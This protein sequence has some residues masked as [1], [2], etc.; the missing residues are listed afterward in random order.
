MRKDLSNI[1]AY[2]VFFLKTKDKIIVWNDD[3]SI[4]TQGETMESALLNAKDAIELM[5]YH[6]F[7]EGKICIDPNEINLEV[8]DDFDGISYL[9]CDLNRYN[10]LESEKKVKK[11][12]TIPESLSKAAEKQGINFSKVLTL[13]L[14]KELELV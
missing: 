14:E 10:K 3:L 9:L 4:V 11:N 2:P 6:N 7:L 1:V 12:C 5:A 13:A 8:E